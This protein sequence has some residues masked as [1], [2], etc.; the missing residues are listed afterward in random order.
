MLIKD[1][2]SRENEALSVLLEKIQI[3]IYVCSLLSVVG[4]ELMKENSWIS[5]QQQN[6]WN[7]SE[8]F[9]GADGRMLEL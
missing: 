3:E 4:N 9:E 7:N 1:K 8:I 2:F 6:I 5:F